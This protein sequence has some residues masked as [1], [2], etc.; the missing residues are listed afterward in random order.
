MAGAVTEATVSDEKDTDKERPGQ[1]LVVEE[2]A[3]RLKKPPLL[4]WSM[5]AGAWSRLATS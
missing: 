2:A 5:V 3:P 1:G 4:Y